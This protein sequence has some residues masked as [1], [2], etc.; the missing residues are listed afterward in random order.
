EAWGPLAPTSGATETLAIGPHRV[1]ARIC[2][3]RGACSGTQA[4]VTVLLVASGP[5]PNTSARS[6]RQRILD[7]AL[8]ATRRILVP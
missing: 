4:T 8:S 2:S 7:A 5:A 3:M 6:L 1:T